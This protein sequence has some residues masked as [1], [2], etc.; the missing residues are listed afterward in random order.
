MAFYKSGAFSPEPY[1]FHLCYYNKNK[2]VEN[3]VKDRKARL[4]PRH[5]W[6]RRNHTVIDILH[7]SSQRNRDQWPWKF[8]F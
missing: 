7:C 4:V 2:G 1:T 8:Y 6:S 3:I 5:R